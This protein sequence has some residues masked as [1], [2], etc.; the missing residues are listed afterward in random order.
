MRLLRDVRFDSSHAWLAGFLDGGGSIFI[1][2]MVRAKAVYYS[3]RVQFVHQDK[4][5]LEVLRRPYGGSLSRH[6]HTWALCLTSRQATALLEDVLPYLQ[7]KHAQAALALQFQ[8]GKRRP[9]GLR[10]TEWEKHRDAMAHQTMRELNQGRK[11]IID[12]PPLTDLAR[13]GR[14][15][16]DAALDGAHFETGGDA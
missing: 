5:L 15:E 13:M 8:L 1:N 9:G 3:M 2:R 6:A 14:A 4:L 10:L 11:V 12:H 7:V 16:R